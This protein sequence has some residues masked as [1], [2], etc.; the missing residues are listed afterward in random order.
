M[1]NRE[2][3]ALVAE[4]VMGWKR[5]TYAEA[6]PETPAYKD[7]KEFTGHWH[8]NE[9]DELLHEF[10]NVAYAEDCDDHYCPEEAWSPSTDISAAWE[11]VE[12]MRN[13]DSVFT[14][15][16]DLDDEYYY[17]AFNTPK[18]H[19]EVGAE[20]MPKAICLAA[21]KAVGVNVSEQEEK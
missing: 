11:V 7:R 8:S 6:H 9:W 19:F 15:W 4:K 17:C 14:L 1:T 2:I 5:M 21:L 20:T 13:R 12:K 16:D 10:K 18:Y 3:D